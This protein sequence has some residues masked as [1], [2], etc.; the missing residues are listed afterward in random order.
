MA[1][2]YIS[3]LKKSKDKIKENVINTP[4]LQSEE[5]YIEQQPTTTI[6]IEKSRGKTYQIN[7]D[8]L[9]EI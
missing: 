8:S 1:S 6:P 7:G 9:V 4:E 3:K 5:I 2:D